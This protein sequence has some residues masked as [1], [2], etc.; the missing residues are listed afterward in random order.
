MLIF[1]SP[2][3]VI[4]VVGFLVCIASIACWVFVMKSAIVVLGLLYRLI[5]VCGAAFCVG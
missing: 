4:A 3:I 5:I 2:C 1:M